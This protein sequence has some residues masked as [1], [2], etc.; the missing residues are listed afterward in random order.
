MEILEEIV[1][2]M[3]ELRKELK[4]PNKNKRKV[5]Q[6]SEKL[7]NYS[8]VVPAYSPTY[9]EIDE[10]LSEANDFLYE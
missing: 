8:E 9:K 4:N 5:L 10:L 3:N 7:T 1:K 6:L 2:T